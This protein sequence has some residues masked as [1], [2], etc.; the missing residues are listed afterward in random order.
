MK[1]IVFIIVAAVLLVSASQTPQQRYIDTYAAIAVKQMYRSGVPASITLAQGIIE[2]R[3]G[4]SP[5]ATEGNNHFGIKCYDWKGRTMKVDDDLKDEC[6]RVYDSPE[7]SFDDHSDFLRYRQRYQFLFDFETTDYKAWANGLKKAGYA[8][9][10]AYASKLIKVIED[11]GLSKY[12]RMKT[13]DF[14]PASAGY[15]LPQEQVEEQPLTSQKN[16][17]RVRVKKV[18][19]SGKNAAAAGTVAAAGTAAIAGTSSSDFEEV[20]PASPSSLE[21]AVVYKSKSAETLH[22]SLARPVFE[23]NGVPFVLSEEG[24]TYASLAEANNLFFKEIL[25]FNDLD[26][27][28]TLMPGTVVYL[29]AKKNQSRKGLDKHIVENEG[30]NLRDISQEYAVK[31]KSI[32]KL[33]GFSPS[34][35]L[36]PGDTIY[37]RK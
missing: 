11:Y 5:L 22:F 35:V 30:E 7:Q 23:K 36:R 16:A 37:L 32:V 14:A 2:S 21:E 28:E 6:F 18:R 8:T 33:N 29:Q 19:K 4:Q 12:D 10:P 27:D 34:H 3:S 1:R 31:E 13:S 24:D 9:D 15:S 17:K 26:A 20:I 25:K